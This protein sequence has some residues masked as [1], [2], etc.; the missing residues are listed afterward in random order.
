[1]DY[2]YL[3]DRHRRSEKKPRA[4]SARENSPF[5]LTRAGRFITFIVWKNYFVLHLAIHEQ[6]PR[7]RFNTIF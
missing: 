3:S 6:S 5:L 7:G 2:E 4:Q 1:M